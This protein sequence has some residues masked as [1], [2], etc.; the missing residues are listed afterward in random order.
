MALFPEQRLRRL[1]RTEELRRLFSETILDV[2]DLIYPLFVVPGRNVKSVIESMP[3]TFHYS[4]DQLPQEADEILS[5]GIPAV[6]LFI[7]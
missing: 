5:L 4:V 6:I 1:R 7:V 3:D 2:S